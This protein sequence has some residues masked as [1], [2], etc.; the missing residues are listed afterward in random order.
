MSERQDAR[1]GNEAYYGGGNA[2][3]AY[4]D[5]YVDIYGFSG[6]RSQELNYHQTADRYDDSFQYPI[7]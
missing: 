7:P 5:E 1:H 3:S 2:G 6:Y 4:Q